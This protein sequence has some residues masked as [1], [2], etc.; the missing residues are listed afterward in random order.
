MLKRADLKLALASDF[1]AEI[2]P[3][4]LHFYDQRAAMESASFAG[5]K[6]GLAL[7][8]RRKRSLAGQEMLIG[9]AQLAHNLLMWLRQELSALT[10]KIAE[11]GIKCL[12]R[13][14]LGMGGRLT[15]KVGRLVKM[16]LPKRHELTRQFHHA[17]AFWADR[18]GVRLVLHQT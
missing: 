10:P 16:R 9:L 7:V 12:V 5:D 13:D 11:Y 4:Q 2:M 14:W 3:A 15:F 1:Q 6:Q 8:K 18:S 17:L